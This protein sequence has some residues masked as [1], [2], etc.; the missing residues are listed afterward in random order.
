M[1]IDRAAEA[2]QLVRI[3]VLEDP[4]AT[5]IRNLR[6]GRFC[7][8]HKSFGADCQRDAPGKAEAMCDRLA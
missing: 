5:L 3:S 4:G 8:G 6:P 2:G 1:P 7:G